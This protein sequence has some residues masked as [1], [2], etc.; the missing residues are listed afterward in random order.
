VAVG[1]LAG[2]LALVPPALL[3]QLANDAGRKAE[4]GEVQPPAAPTPSSGAV[5][6]PLLSARR[7]PGIV[8]GQLK[9]AGLIAG[10][11]ALG[12]SLNAKS[13]VRVDLDGQAVYAVGDDRLVLPASNLKLVTAAVALDRLG[14]DDRFTTSVV[15]PAPIDGVV[16]GDVYLIGGG[17]PVLRTD[18]FLAAETATS[19]PLYPE[20]PGTRFEGLVEAM[21]SRGITHINGRVLGD[22]GRYDDQRFVATWPASYRTSHEAG[23]LGALLVDDGFIDVTAGAVVDDPAVGA[24]T[25]LTAMLRSRGVDVGVDAGR[26]GPPDDVE[27]V[28]LG[29]VQ[30]PPLHDVVKEMLSSSDDN[31]AELLL[32]EIG[33]TKG[34]GG[35]TEAGLAVVHDTLAAWGV[36]L[37]GVALTDGS[38]LDRG[39]RVT[40]ALLIGILDRG[41][42]AND[43]VAG[44]ATAGQPGTTMAT[45]FLT[46]PFLGNLRAKTGTLT[47]ARALSG[48]F[49]TPD[50]HTLTFSLVYNGDKPAEADV[51]WDRL[52]NALS[53]YPTSPDVSAFEPLPPRA[54]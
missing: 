14:R 41:G 20:N 50:G 16:D 3:A 2:V 31:T 38:G 49:T 46:A 43:I 40:C 13:C 35:T 53:K 17:D 28:P 47:G 30:S 11:G 39:N 5:V 22:D 9:T 32:K 27:L 23:P 12:E 19:P 1:A 29:T 18:A 37:D 15:G 10:L 48:A 44:L 26:G 34:A 8:T 51:L 36:P 4:R 25:A 24:A 6:T 33:F 21:L 45:H 52:G 7:V 42:P 54:G